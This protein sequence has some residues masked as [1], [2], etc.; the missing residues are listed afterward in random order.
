MVPAVISA[1]PLAGAAFGLV[2]ILFIFRAD[3][4]CIHDL[5]AGTH[6]VTA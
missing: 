1:I 6:V 3:R 5:I 4:R 2:D